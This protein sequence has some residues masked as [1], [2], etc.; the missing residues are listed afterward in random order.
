MPNTTP[1]PGRPRLSS[2]SWL[3]TLLLA[4]GLLLL[5][6]RG[7]DWRE[8][9][10]TLQQGRADYLA[11]ACV[12]LTISFMLRGIRWGV[13]LSGKQ[14][15]PPLTMFWATSAGYLGNTFLPARAGEIIRS[16]L[17]GRASGISQ[18]FVLA[19]ALTERML[20]ALALVLICMVA[21][22][23]MPAIPPWLGTAAQIIGIIG[24]IGLVVLAVA[25][26]LEP[27][28]ATLLQRM[29]LPA[30]LRD[31]L[32]ELLAQFLLGLNAVLHPRRAV[33][34][35]LLTVLIWLL[36]A[37]IAITT[38]HAL[39]LALTLPQAFVLLAALGL[40][41]AAPSTPGYIGIYQFV[42][43]TV[44]PLFDWSRS[45]ALA[46]I[47]VFQAITIVVVLLWGFIGLWRL[48]ATRAD[49]AAAN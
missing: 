12:V 21:L 34:F 44:L 42:A 27:F 48:G 9:A 13:I 5:A 23:L 4:A 16:V 28:F 41:S 26:R 46:Y 40:S 49:I 19:T 45:A 24:L 18:S 15:I 43:V 36:D 10:A 37:V 17:V 25:P 11:L 1:Q 7:I 38:A 3:L 20:D 30:T 8:L 47:L 29:P 39:G 6:L 22:V 33:L 14:R 31:K 32:T 35:T 2:W